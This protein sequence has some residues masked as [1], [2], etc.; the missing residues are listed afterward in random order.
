MG[1]SLFNL[2]AHN[3]AAIRLNLLKKNH[4][5][6]IFIFLKHFLRLIISNDYVCLI[7]WVCNN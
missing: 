1:Y 6:L 7:V 4:P 3:V 5:L 2:Y